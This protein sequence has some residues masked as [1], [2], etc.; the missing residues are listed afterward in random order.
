MSENRKGRFQYRGKKKT[1]ATTDLL[2][3]AHDLLVLELE[4]HLKAEDNR[5]D[6]IKHYGDSRIPKPMSQR[7]VV[8]QAITNVQA[9][10]DKRRESPIIKKP[11]GLLK[12]LSEKSCL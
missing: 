10:I 11:F 7:S 4:Q 5:K 2:W 6:N 3:V 8:I 9:E 1:S 12:E